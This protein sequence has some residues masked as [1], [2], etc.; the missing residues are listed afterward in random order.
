MYV[1]KWICKCKD[2]I[3]RGSNI[4]NI[5]IYEEKEESYRMK[6]VWLIKRV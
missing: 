4:R 1:N 3:K 6:I 5:D 2:D